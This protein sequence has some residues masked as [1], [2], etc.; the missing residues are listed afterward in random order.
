MIICPAMNLI[1]I[2]SWARAFFLGF[3][4]A[5][6]H[7]QAKLFALTLLCSF[8]GLNFRAFVVLLDF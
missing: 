7:S 5:L 2:Q 3:A 1:D 8:M 6:S 4:L